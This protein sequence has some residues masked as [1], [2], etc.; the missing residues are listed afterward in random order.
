M[1][2]HACGTPT[3]PRL[4]KLLVSVVV[5][6]VSPAYRSPANRSRAPSE[7]SA[8][9]RWRGRPAPGWALAGSASDERRRRRHPPEWPITVRGL[10]A[11][12]RVWTGGQPN[13]PNKQPRSRANRAPTH[14]HPS[15]H[16]VGGRWLS[17][18][19]TGVAERGKTGNRGTR[20]KRGVPAP[21]PDTDTPGGGPPPPAP[22]PPAHAPSPPP[23]GPA[24]PNP[25]TPHG[26]RLGGPP[27]HPDRGGAPRRAAHPA[28]SRAPPVRGVSPTLYAVPSDDSRPGDYPTRPPP[29]AVPVARPPP[30]EPPPP[31]FRLP[32]HIFPARCLALRVFPSSMLSPPSPLPLRPP[33]LLP[34]PPFFRHPWS[35]RRSHPNPISS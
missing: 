4:L 26:E 28:P 21:T 34:A 1:T 33:P 29:A 9:I 17:G 5:V 10:R 32:A 6:A 31:R 8:A 14:V 27:P 30:A 7:A 13:R 3:A 23:P 35:T 2:P 22:V 12:R 15:T 24:G 16:V 18:A 19:R 11:S 25:G 20:P